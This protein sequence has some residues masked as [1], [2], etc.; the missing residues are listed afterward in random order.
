MR[1]EVGDLAL[2]VAEQELVSHNS[3]R[4]GSKETQLLNYLMLNE[5]KRIFNFGFISTCLER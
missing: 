3:I 4:L 1:V 5:G 2:N